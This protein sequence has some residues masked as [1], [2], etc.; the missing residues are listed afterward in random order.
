MNIKPK[1]NKWQNLFMH[2]YFYTYIGYSRVQALH[3]H[4]RKCALYVC[5]YVSMYITW[6][7]KTKLCKCKRFNY[8]FRKQTETSTQ[9][10]WHWICTSNIHVSKTLLKIYKICRP[11]NFHMFCINRKTNNETR[12]T[13]YYASSMYRNINLR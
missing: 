3:A 11:L 2:K 10:E 9:Q 8:I 7:S 6:R 13:N 1:K 4:V 12:K 5:M